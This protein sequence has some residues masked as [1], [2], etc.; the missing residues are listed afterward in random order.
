MERQNDPWDGNKR[1]VIQS[2]HQNLFHEIVIF[3][4]LELLHKHQ[5]KMKDRVHYLLYYL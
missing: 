2:C 5:Y 3:K 4:F 1:V